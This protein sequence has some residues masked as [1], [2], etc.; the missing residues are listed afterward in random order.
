MALLMGGHG[1]S[2]ETRAH[3]AGRAS[4]VAVA[5]VKKKRQGRKKVVA[6]KKWRGGSAKLPRAREGV[7][8]Y[9]ETLG[10]GFQMGQMGLAQNAKPGRA[11]LFP[12]YFMVFWLNTDYRIANYFPEYKCSCEIRL[13]GEQSE[14]DF[15]RSGE[16][17]SVES[18]IWI[19]SEIIPYAWFENK[20]SWDLIGFGFLVGEG[21]SWYFKIIVDMGFW[22]RF[23]HEI[24][25]WVR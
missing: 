23:G 25:G 14:I 22:V 10:L 20:S 9:R 16:K 11:N 21:E 15:G 8:I 3:G 19:C 17:N 7:H 18:L 6:G 4:L 24:F 2:R 13:Y 1:W 12:F 5:A